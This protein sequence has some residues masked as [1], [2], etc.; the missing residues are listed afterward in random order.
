MEF[1]MSQGN[2]YVIPIKA[3]QKKLHQQLQQ[4]A[5]TSLLSVALQQ[6]Q[7][8][9]RQT[10]RGASVFELSEAI[11]AQGSAVQLG[12]EVIRQGTRRGEPHAERHYDLTRWT[13]KAD[14]LQALIRPH[15]GIENS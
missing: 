6:E 5:Q 9:D 13:A 3:N 11:K 14:A 1:I 8:Q 4:Q 7:T 10:T 12:V 15:W 2:D